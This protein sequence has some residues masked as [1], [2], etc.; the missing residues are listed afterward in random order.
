MS[1]TRVRGKLGARSRHPARDVRRSPRKPPGRRSTRFVLLGAMAV[2]LGLLGVVMVLSSSSVND[3]RSYGDAWYHLKRQIVWFAL[4][5][6]ALMMMMRVDYRRLRLLAQPAIVLAVGLLVM[7]LIPGIGISANGSARWIGIGSFTF[8]PSELAKLGVLL[9]S[10]DLLS[11]PGRPSSQ[12]GL[13]LRPVLLVTVTIGALLMLEPDLGTVVIVVAIVASLLF[14]SGTRLDVLVG[15]GAL[16]IAGIGWLSLSADYRRQ[17]ILGMLDPWTDPLNTG[18]QTIQAGVAVSSGGI[19]G[20]GLGASRAKWGFLPFAHT[21]FI[22]AIV[23]EEWGLVGA[24]MVILAFLVIGFVGLSTALKAPDQFGQLLAAGV[25]CWILVQAFVNIGA[26][27]GVVPITGVPLPFV[28]SGGT[29][30]V[31]TMAA[32]GILLNI[33]RQA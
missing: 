18:W 28:S 12:L 33:A 25:T 1:D 10:A 14:F 5:L 17:R 8:Q 20:I 23:A 15:L 22:F 9:Y 2:L 16:G 21:D 13:T 7:V 19:T 27:L 32:Y 24:G 31:V 26:V 30:L 4:G 3:L 6:L 11:R 29:A